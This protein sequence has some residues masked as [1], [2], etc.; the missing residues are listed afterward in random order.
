[1]ASDKC[2]ERLGTSLYD[3]HQDP[4]V[5]LSRVN[6]KDRNKF[7]KRVS[8]CG[9]EQELPVTLYDENSRPRRDI[10]TLGAFLG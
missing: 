4:G 2:L 5:F 9:L 7:S 3:L 6:S 8:E 10:V 1:M